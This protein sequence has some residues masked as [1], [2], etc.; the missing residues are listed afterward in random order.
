MKVKHSFF[1]DFDTNKYYLVNKTFH[2][3]EI[4]ENELD[5]V[6]DQIW[7]EKARRLQL[8]RWRKIKLQQA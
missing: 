4:Y 3:Y 1:K 6:D 8:R 5:D 2:P 7:S